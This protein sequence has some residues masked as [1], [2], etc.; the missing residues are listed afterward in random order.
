MHGTRTVLLTGGTGYLGSHIAAAFESA[1]WRARFLGRRQRPPFQWRLGGEP[2]PGVFED[3]DLLVHGAYD[4]GLTRRDRIR[5]INIEGTRTLLAAAA[6]HGVSRVILVSSIAAFEGCQSDYGRAKQ[7]CERI[8]AGHNALIVRPGLVYGEQNAGVYGAM[9]RWVGTLPVN[10]VLVPSPDLY[11][12]HVQD[13][14]E[15]FT[16]IANRADWHPAT[17]TAASQSPLSF[18]EITRMLQEGLGVRKPMMPVPWRLPWLILKTME[19]A[20]LEPPFRS[21][22]LVG[23]MKSNPSPDFSGLRGCATRFRDFTVD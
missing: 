19:L 17:V 14:R 8:A 11:T 7:E 22:G 1:R 6:S 16:E 13:L 23:L 21:D 9:E 2:D 12:C 4:M 20:H 18:R 15:L 5:R 3:V 10:P